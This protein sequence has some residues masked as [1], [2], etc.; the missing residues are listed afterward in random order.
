MPRYSHRSRTRRR[1]RGRFGPLFKLLCVIAVIVALTV[2][3]TVFFRVEQVTV[4]GNQ[5]YTEE[6]IIAASGIQLGS[7]L[8]SLN[9]VRIDRNLRTTLPYIGEL[10]IN[11]SLPSTVVITVTEWEAV[12]QVAAPGVEQVTAYQEEAGEKAVTTA[13]EP[14]LISVKGKL[15]EPAPANSTAIAVTG[16]TPLAPQAGSF[17]EVPEEELTKLEALTGLLEAL[18]VREVRGEVSAIRLESTYLV[19]RYAGRFDVKMRLNADFNYDVRRM[20]SV[21]QRMEAERGEEVA[22]S[23][24]LTQEKYSAV[25]SEAGDQG[26]R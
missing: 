20:E 18:E 4:T 21:R 11:R 8:Y 6:E 24:D 15:L 10:T 7:N 14:W 3:A 22:G 2:G 5:R 25:F 13:Q 12:A 9:K 26:V 1:N 16:L 19:A 23:I 17:L